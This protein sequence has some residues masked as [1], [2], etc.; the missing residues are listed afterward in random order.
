[1]NGFQRDNYTCIVY[2]N[3][4]NGSFMSASDL[5]YNEAFELIR[6]LEQQAKEQGT[7]YED[8]FTLTFHRKN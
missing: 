4:K 7:Y 1:M 3:T 2:E 5:S 6:K 8:R